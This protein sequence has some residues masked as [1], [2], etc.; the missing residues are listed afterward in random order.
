MGGP[1]DIGVKNGSKYFQWDRAGRDSVSALI[2]ALVLTTLAKVDDIQDQQHAG[3]IDA[4][5][6]DGRIEAVEGRLS[7]HI[8]STAPQVIELQSKL[9]E[10]G[11]RIAVVEDRSLRGN[12]HPGR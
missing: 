1:G 5:T 2:L 8:L 10:L 12:N 11:E 6:R 4:A 9:G 7:D 3:A